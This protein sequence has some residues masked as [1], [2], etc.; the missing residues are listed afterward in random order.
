MITQFKPIAI[1]ALLILNAC[2][3][4]N[5]QK[6]IHSYSSSIKIAEKVSKNNEIK[7]HNVAIEHQ[8]SIIKKKSISKTSQRI[9]KIVIEGMM[10]PICEK[11]ALHHL[12]KINGIVDIAIQ[13]HNEKEEKH[14][15]LITWN[16]EHNP[17]LGAIVDAVE[18][19][20]FI[21]HK[22]EGRLRG[23]FTGNEKKKLFIVEGTGEPFALT[24][25]VNNIRAIH[26]KIWERVQK[27]VSFWVNLIIWRDMHDGV[28]KITLI[29]SGQQ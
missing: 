7:K 16:K 4:A 24:Q 9:F 23:K 13:G 22:L 8:T 18:R 28:Y 11:S 26:P 15:I 10:C 3:R 17:P 20:D 19:E 21:L 27:D 29:P 1:I 14:I 6:K 2:G 25:A 5:N 12:R